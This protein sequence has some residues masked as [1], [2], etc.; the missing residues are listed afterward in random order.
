[1]KHFQVLHSL[2]ND[3]VAL[4]QHLSFSSKSRYFI[5]A[6]FLSMIFSFQ[7]FAQNHLVSGTV[8]DQDGKELAGSSVTVKNTQIA[9][10]TDASGK[11]S[12]NV[13]NTGAVLVFTFV[14]FT[15]QEIPVNN[16]S[17]I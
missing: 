15:T 14:G 11:F 2:W 17:V 10:L 6:F 3:M 8:L 1:M 7:T 4:K 9:T 13:P 12:I 16:K 5:T